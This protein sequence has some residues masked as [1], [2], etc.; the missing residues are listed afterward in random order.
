MLLFWKK[1]SP[2]EHRHFWRQDNII[3]I[4]LDFFYSAHLT[5][6]V[7]SV[8]QCSSSQTSVAKTVKRQ[9]T[10][11]RFIVIVKHRSLLLWPPLPQSKYSKPWN[12]V[13]TSAIQRLDYP[14]VKRTAET[15]LRTKK[16][17][18]SEPAV[19]TGSFT[20][21]KHVSDRI[22]TKLTVKH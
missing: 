12:D 6:T 21:L 8:Q 1:Y 18:Q 13:D 7:Y 9:T 19:K 2:K 17:M 16:F 11:Q 3:N 22:W 10:A 15:T 5:K 20:G 14:V 4:Q